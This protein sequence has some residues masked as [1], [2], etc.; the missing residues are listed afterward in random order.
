MSGRIVLFGATGYTGELTA[1]A[2]VDRG[3][4]PVLAARRRDALEALAARLGGLETRVAD[5]AQ[6]ATLRG[7]VER[8]DV[9]ISTVGPFARL[10]EPVVLAAIDAGAH[11]LDSTGESVFIR[12]V[13]E[14]HGPAAAA[15]GCGLLTAF[16]YDW[17]PGNL[18]GALALRDAG[19]RA[20]RVETGY[21]VTGDSRAAVASGGTRAS[22]LGILLAPAH[23]LRGGRLVTEPTARRVRDFDL[24]RRRAA[25]VSVGG[26]EP[27]ALPRIAPGLRDVGVYLGVPGAPA[28]AAQALGLGT[29]VLGRLP[30]AR[31]GLGALLRPLAPGSTGGPDAGARA[32]V[33]ALV[34][35]EAFDA[36]GTRLGGV[37]LSGVNPYDFTAA[38]LAWGAQTAAADGLR[39]TGALGPVDGFGLDELERGCTRAGMARDT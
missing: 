27:L 29:S 21:F 35:A 13:F 6:P 26:S 17:V 28:R 39:G 2:L 12:A 38:I 10:G 15:A 4:R 36:R 11:Y 20:T 33:G 5:V 18:A 16:G 8:G 7:L 34:V 19:E 9:L 32:R 1:R 24:G 31:A 14:R 3:V 22:A 37:R 23:A 25:A 30:A